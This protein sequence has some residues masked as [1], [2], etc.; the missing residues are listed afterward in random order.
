MKGRT[1][2]WYQRRDCSATTLLFRKYVV[3]ETEVPEDWK[4]ANVSPSL[5]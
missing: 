3:E 2:Q 1:F 5:Y 4:Q